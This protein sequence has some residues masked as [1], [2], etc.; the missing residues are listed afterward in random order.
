MCV[1]WACIHMY[2]YV[3]ICSHA[4]T[5][6]PHTH[7]N[8]CVAWV[9]GGS[10]LESGNPDNY[11]QYLHSH[12]LSWEYMS[13]IGGG[14]GSANS[15][16]PS[17]T[18]THTHTHSHTHAHSLAHTHTHAHTPAH[19]HTYTHVLVSPYSSTACCPCLFVL[20]PLLSRPV[21]PS[22]SLCHSLPS[23]R[24]LGH[25]GWS[26]LGGH[27]CN[28]NASAAAVRRHQASPLDAHAGCLLPSLFLC[29]C[30]CLLLSPLLP[31]PA[32]LKQSWHLSV[33]R[34]ASCV[35]QPSLFVRVAAG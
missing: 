12:G 27:D 6:P 25:T 18:H 20:S 4:H 30:L 15:G 21:C 34:L 23:S 19:T 7:A 28:A 10:F 1:A 9:R 5:P 35:R 17:I 24:S 31:H 2:M 11:W 14:K 3:Y 29:L 33:L 16:C 22:P 8:T 32:P 13:S 26:R